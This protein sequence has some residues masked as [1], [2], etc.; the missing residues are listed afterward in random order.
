MVLFFLVYFARGEGFAMLVDAFLGCSLSP[1]SVVLVLL[2]LVRHGFCA[3][4]SA[5]RLRC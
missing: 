1:Y 4:S 3:V 2:V 5:S